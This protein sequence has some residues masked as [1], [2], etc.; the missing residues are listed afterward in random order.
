MM[1]LNALKFCFV[2]LIGSILFLS[3]CTA[4]Q[5]SAGLKKDIQKLLDADELLKSE[6]ITLRIVDVSQGHVVLEMTTGDRAVRQAIKAGKDV[7]TDK[8]ESLPYAKPDVASDSAYFTKRNVDI[9][10]GLLPELKRIKGVAGLKVTAAVDTPLDRAED[11]QNQRQYAQALNAYRQLADRGDAE[12]QFNIG[13]YYREGMGVT[14]AP[15]IA[16]EYFQ[17][18]ATQGFTQA[19]YNLAA[20]YQM[21]QPGVAP[22]VAKAL[23]WYQKAAQSGFVYSQVN[24]ALIYYY[25]Q[26]VKKDYRKSLAWFTKAADQG[27][28]RALINLGTMNETGRGTA[29]DFNKAKQYFQKA[30]DMDSVEGCSA[31]AGFYA[32]CEDD[33]FIDG[34]KAVQYAEKAVSLIPKAPEFEGTVWGAYAAAQ[35]RIGQFDKAIQASQKSIELIGKNELYLDKARLSGLADERLHLELYKKHQPFVFHP[36]TEEDTS[37]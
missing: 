15:G 37:K 31:L 10:K 34:A 25:G 29:R 3:T 14:K 12:A 35:A 21:G 20:I 7:R 1:R 22:D 6:H 36:E 13:Q 4:N 32:S 26:G 28:A 16:F 19:M 24:L 30:A 17:K 9:L 23:E 11:L 8:I 2:T 33:Q 27:S 18:S 5:E